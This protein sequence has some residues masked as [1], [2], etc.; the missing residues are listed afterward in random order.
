LFGLS[1]KK[2]GAETVK[3]INMFFRAGEE[4]NKGHTQGHVGDPYE[5]NKIIG[6]S[7]CHGGEDGERVT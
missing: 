5:N 3:K 1:T 7:K 4:V 6:S 2:T